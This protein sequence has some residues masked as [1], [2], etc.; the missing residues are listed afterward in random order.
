MTY[1][2][3][4]ARFFE[5][6][7]Y[8]LLIPAVLSLLMCFLFPLSLVISIPIFSIGVTLLIGYFKHSRGN[9]SEAKTI[10]LWIATFIYNLIPLLLLFASHSIE[11]ESFQSF[12][13]SSCLSNFAVA[14]LTIS[15]LLSGNA[16]FVVAY[17]D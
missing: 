3:T 10:L 16:F 8:P 2:Q 5:I 9:L 14:W 15:V 17:K 7:C 13:I 11:K 6:I 12:S 4:V 1:S